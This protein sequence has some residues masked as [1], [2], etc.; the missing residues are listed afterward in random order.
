[1]RL[2]NLFYAVKAKKSNFCPLPRSRR[3]E[4][5]NDTSVRHTQQNFFP[6]SIAASISFYLVFF[7]SLSFCFAN[8]AKTCNIYRFHQR[9]TVTLINDFP[10]EILRSFPRAQSSSC[11]AR[12]SSGNCPRQ[13]RIDTKFAIPISPSIP[14]RQL[15][16]KNVAP[17]TQR[18]GFTPN[19]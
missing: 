3:K 1:M 4:P 10:V 15:R 14:Q 16:K 11:L 7:L 17:R 19:R 12:R 9:A 13:S 6:L 8:P 18:V 5:S 2:F